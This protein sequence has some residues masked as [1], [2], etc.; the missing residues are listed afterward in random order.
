[1]AQKTKKLGQVYTPPHIV[2]D[3]LDLLCY[4]GETILG[5]NV[6]DN[7]C[8]NGAFLYEIAKR[9]IDAYQAQNG[10]LNG[11][12]NDL[13]KY[14]HGIE[15]DRTEW[16]KCVENLNKIHKADWDIKLGDTLQINDF[17]GEMDFVVGNPPY[18]RIHN[19]ENN[20]EKVRDY[21]F[22]QN[23]MADL[24]LVFYDIALRQ[25][26]ANGKLA[27][28]TPNSFYS[29]I[30]GQE[31]RNYII[32]EK[33]LFAVIDLGHYQPFSATAYTTI[34]AFDMAKQSDI[35][36]YSKYDNDGKINFVENLIIKDAF[37]NGKM[38]L[39]RKAEQDFLKSIQNYVPR[40]PNKVQVKNAFATLADDVF[41]QKDFSFNAPEII[42]CLKASTGEWKK[43]IFP[44]VANGFDNLANDTQKYLERH[45]EKLVN[46]SLDRKTDWYLFGRSQAIND[47]MSP[48]IAINTTIKDARNIKINFVDK[49]QGVYS[50]LYI[51]T[52]EP[53]QRIET[54]IKNGDFI[55]YIKTI[56]KCKSGGY[57]TFSSGDL[58]QYLLYKMGA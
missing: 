37:N 45:K 23:G 49:G 52:D 4:S 27:F 13:A 48:K 44:Y 34:C 58:K 46:R 24:F 22:A 26:N 1:M 17:D 19:L 18:V 41:I 33:H 47:T 14:I 56:G 30:A 31:F 25:L 15:I 20:F 29:S 5:K 2:A 57:Y 32:N 40:N 10:T 9:Y 36:A 38:I 7:S 11:V 6:L 8:G 51:L 3:M 12:E 21:R 28:I 50:G 35:L 55:N 39:A 54:I 42:D 53:L 43:C 16:Q